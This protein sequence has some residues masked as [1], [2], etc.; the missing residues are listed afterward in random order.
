M[1]TFNKGVTNDLRKALLAIQEESLNGLI[2]DLRNNPGG[3]YEEA[4]STASQFLDTGNVLLEKNALGKVT[5]IP[6]RTGG[7][8]TKMSL[9]VLINGGTSSGAEIVAG[10]LQDAQRARLV[11]E[12][13]FGTGTVLETFPLSDGS[14]LM[15][16]IEEWLTPAGH[17]IWHQG[18]SPDVAVPLPPE[19]IPLIP[20][21]EKE[22]TVEELKE[23]KDIQLLRALQLLT[24]Q[25][26]HQVRWRV[27]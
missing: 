27:G 12:K 16:A 1:A 20:A 11:G 18:I 17:M 26:R 25:G 6:V 7:V 8:A 19:V 23:S 22:L 21:T 2:F 9:V 13:T 15:L 14:A 3:L 10:A 5:P 4:V 24:R